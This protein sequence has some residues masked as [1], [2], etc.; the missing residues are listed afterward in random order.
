MVI[1][2]QFH[3]LGRQGFAGSRLRIPPTDHRLVVKQVNR[4][5]DEHGARH[6]FAGM[7]ECLLKR[8]REIP[9]PADRVDA[10]HVR[11]HQGLLVDILQC[12]ATFQDRWRGTAQNDDRR[13][14]QLG[15]LDG[16]YGIG[17]ARAG[18]HR[19]YTGQTGQ[20]GTCIRGE[21]AGYLMANIDDL[22]APLFRAGQYWRNMPAA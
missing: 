17:E 1:E 5:L 10:L 8:G 4:A 19:C 14:C 16:R 3:R 6:T 12:A 9:H 21:D 7:A 22:N 2:V 15:I 11:G 18:S 20:P 13:L